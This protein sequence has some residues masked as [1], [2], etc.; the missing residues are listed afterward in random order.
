M[1]TELDLLQPSGLSSGRGL[2]PTKLPLQ[3]GIS[4]QNVITAIFA[5]D[6]R[7]VAFIARIA[8]DPLRANALLEWGDRSRWVTDRRLAKKWG[9]GLVLADP[10]WAATQL[11]MDGDQAPAGVPFVFL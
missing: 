5:A 3:S 7:K 8:V 10:N 6:G 1:I 11:A 4:A 9:V 2:Q